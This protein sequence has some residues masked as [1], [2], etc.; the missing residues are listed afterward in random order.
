MGIVLR[1]QNVLVMVPDKYIHNLPLILF[2]YQLFVGIAARALSEIVEFL[3][4]IYLL[5]FNENASPQKY[6][7]EEI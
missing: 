5:T 6:L 3:L 1:V 4:K 7:K 2:K